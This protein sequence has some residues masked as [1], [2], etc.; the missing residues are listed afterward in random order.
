MFVPANNIFPRHSDAN[1]SKCGFLFGKLGFPF[2]KLCFPL[3][4]LLETFG[5]SLGNLGCQLEIDENH[6]S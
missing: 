5:F 3:D 2:E 1:Y 6:I 4:K